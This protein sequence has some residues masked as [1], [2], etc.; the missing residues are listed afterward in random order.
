MDV[1][2]N[3]YVLIALRIAHIGGGIIWV[4]S[5][6]LL[7]T[8]LLPAVR[9]SEAAGQK[10]MEN[11]GPRFGKMMG[12]VTT[13]TVISGALLYAR[14]FASGVEWIWTTG[15]GIGFTIGAIAA[16]I[17]FFLGTLY[18]GRAQEKIRAYG[19]AMASAGGPPQPNQIAE[20][21][22][23]QSTLMKTYQFDIALLVIAMLAMATARYL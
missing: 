12:I 23:M 2:L 19:M 3:H 16:L 22:R 6:I 4:G 8:I 13:V 5:A 1:L 15:A 21:N 17:S 14:F 9:S 7:M 20:M 11:F 18:F 10:F